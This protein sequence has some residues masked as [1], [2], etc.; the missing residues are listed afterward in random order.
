MRNVFNCFAP[1]H[2]AVLEGKEKT[3]MIE[4]LLIG[5]GFDIAQGY[6]TDYGDFIAFT[7]SPGN[8]CDEKIKKICGENPFIRYFKKIKSIQNW[9]DVEKEIGVIC[10]CFSKIMAYLD[11]NQLNEAVKRENLTKKE[12]T[13]VDSFHFLFRAR[14]AEIIF[15][16]KYASFDAYEVVKELRQYHE[17]MITVLAYYF[18]REVGRLKSEEIAKPDCI[19]KKHFDYVIDFNYTPTYKNFGIKDEDVLFIHGR[20]DNPNTMVLGMPDGICDDIKLV[21]FT[22]FFQ[23]IQKHT[24]VLNV[25]R[26]SGGSAQAESIAHVFGMSLGKNDEDIIRKVFN[27][28]DMVLIYYNGQKDYE[29]KIVNLISIF[30]RDSVEK[31]INDNKWIFIDLT[32][33]TENQY[34]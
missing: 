10:L 23:R 24:G 25:S 14:S 2:K 3:T 18:D 5:N 17:E 31:N 8:E 26:L 27:N 16:Q 19:N 28:V 32:Y 12:R 6:K 4:T 33:E 22:K 1:R 29:G 11:S 13:V 15:D 20:I 21:Y 30:G 7:E 9:I 34:K